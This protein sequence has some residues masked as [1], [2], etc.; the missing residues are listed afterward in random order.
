MNR[1]L[2][3]KYSA[4]I[5]GAVVLKPDYI[6]AEPKT[7]FKKTILCI[8][9][10]GVNINDFKNQILQISFASQLKVQ[11]DFEARYLGSLDSHHEALHHLTQSN[12]VDLTINVLHEKFDPKLLFNIESQQQYIIRF[13]GCDAAHYNMER[14]H[15][16]LKRYIEYTQQL[17][18]YIYSEKLFNNEYS[19]V[20]ATEMGRDLDGGEMEMNSGTVCSHHC[21]DEARVIGRIIIS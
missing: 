19:L 15:T 2:F 6:F 5:G 16:A 4:L 9:G 13:T 17:S 8:W 12:P 10:E 11:H 18:E 3:I 14:Y 20:I 21:T 1:K 7:V